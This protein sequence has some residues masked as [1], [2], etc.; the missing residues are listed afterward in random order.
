M[1]SLKNIGQ[2]MNGVGNNTRNNIKGEGIMKNFFKAIK[3]I[4]VGIIIAVVATNHGSDIIAMFKDKDIIR[5]ERSVVAKINYD[6]L[7]K[8]TLVALDR[9]REAAYSYA[10]NELE[11]WIAEVMARV[12]GDFLDDY[13]GFVQTKC[14]EI[15]ALGHT[16]GHLLVPIHIKNAEEALA[17]ELEERISNT[18]IRPEI[19]E[20]RIK[21]ITQ[22]AIEVYLSTLDKE[23]QQVQEAY[24]IPTPAWNEYVSNLCGMTMNIESKAY[25]I[26]VKTAIMTT[27]GIAV[28]G[29][30]PAV[31]IARKVSER[32]AVK[33]GANVAE[34]AGV[35]V[36]TKA[37]AKTGGT[38]VVKAIPIAG[39]A[40]TAGIVIW[41]VIDYNVGAEKGKKML[42]EN[43]A[44]YLQEIKTEFLA[45]SEDTVMGSI[46]QWENSLKS[47]IAERK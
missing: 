28:L 45:D 9:A 4:F 10:D 38:T 26:S 44:D 1:K 6:R 25:P 47:R 5:T 22:G 27:S 29:A 30:I 33:A 12:D 42:R 41:D 15:R 20:Q 11:K 40:V 8:E 37:V 31:K 17:E 32:I 3:Y 21:N 39:W 34:K 46:T 36:A 13:F 24:K 35:K 14:R 7:D 18:V 16:I 2:N 43:V 19:S 23:F